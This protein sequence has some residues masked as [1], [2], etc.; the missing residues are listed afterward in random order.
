MTHAVT[1]AKEFEKIG[2]EMVFY[3]LNICRMKEIM[4]SAIFFS[5]NVFFLAFCFTSIVAICVKIKI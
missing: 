3:V 5:K 4:S 1:Q 2:I